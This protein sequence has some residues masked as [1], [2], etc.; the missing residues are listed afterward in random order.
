VLDDVAAEDELW[1][2][3]HVPV[4]RA[5][6]CCGEGGMAGC[7]ARLGGDMREATLIIPGQICFWIAGVSLSSSLLR[8]I[9]RQGSELGGRRF[10]TRSVDAGSCGGIG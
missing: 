7:A 3:D 10:R 9:L 6:A 8:P 2:A 5:F 1:R 4:G